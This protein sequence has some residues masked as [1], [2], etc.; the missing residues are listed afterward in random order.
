M[1]MGNSS[2]LIEFSSLFQREGEKSLLRYPYVQTNW[3]MRDCFLHLLIVLV[4]QDKASLAYIAR[5]T[6]LSCDSFTI[7]RA[8]LVKQTSAQTYT[9][10]H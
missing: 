9:H 3:D 4:D 10:V 5:R 6:A 1:L 8:L 2:C 7:S